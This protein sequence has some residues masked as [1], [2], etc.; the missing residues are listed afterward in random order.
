MMHEKVGNSPC[1]EWLNRTEPYTRRDFIRDV[2][3]GSSALFLFGNL[4][5][6]HVA[7]AKEGESTVYHMIVVDYTKC[8]GCRTC[9]T[10]CSAFNHKQTVNGE[11]LLGLGN[12]Y[13]SNIRVYPYNPD[14]D[15]PVTCAMCPDNPCIE[16]CPVSPHPET[17]RKALYRDDKTG[18]IKNDLERCIAC[19][20]CAEA[21]RTQRSGIIVPNPETN[22]PERMCTL[23][24]G[25]PQC[26]KH[27]PFE[28]LSHVEV[29]VG[30][31]F[32]GLTSEKIA[33]ELIKRWYHR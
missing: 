23:C 14:V 25:D 11:A 9:E 18:A 33:V 5:V 3:F 15:I 19:G 30:Q 4:G 1:F 22:K 13:Y 27:C 32:Y 12:P 26:V 17:G 21:C 2:A 7:E 20:S 31:E 6:L 28:A 16:A 8:T 24:D 10:V 29:S